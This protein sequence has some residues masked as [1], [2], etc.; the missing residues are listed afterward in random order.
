MTV[1]ITIHAIERYR[2][3]VPDAA[4]WSDDQIRAALDSPAVRAAAQIG[5]RYVRLHGGQ[6]IVIQDATVVTVMPSDNYR[7]QV[8]R[9]GLSRFGRV[10]RNQ[11][12]TED[13]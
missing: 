9:K 13:T 4:Q 10:V 6:R 12:D 7:K 11:G 5:A 2:E 3:R 8:R 1:H